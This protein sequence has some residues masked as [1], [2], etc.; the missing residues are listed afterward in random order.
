[1]HGGGGGD[2][3]GDGGCD[4][5]GEGGGGGGGG[6]EGGGGGG[7]SLISMHLTASPPLQYIFFLIFSGLQHTTV[8]VTVFSFLSYIWFW[9]SLVR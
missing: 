5:G 4:G 7:G 3:G 9:I 1:V 6:G 8:I 2:G